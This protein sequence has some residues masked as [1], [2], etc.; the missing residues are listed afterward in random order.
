MR[1]SNGPAVLIQHNRNNIPAN[2]E[3]YSANE[4]FRYLGFGTIPFV[5]KAD[6]DKHLD[7]GNHI[8]VGGIDEIE[9]C[10]EKLGIQLPDLS[11]PEGLRI[12]L[13][14]PVKQTTLDS[15]IFDEDDNYPIFVKPVRGKRFTGTVL[16]YYGDYLQR[17]RSCRTKEPVWTSPVVDFAAEYR[18]FVRY[19]QILDV[20][21]YD[22]RW[23]LLCSSRTIERA[24]E[25]YSGSPD[26]PAAYAIDFG[27]VT[28]P[29]VDLTLLVEV[30]DG[31]SVGSYGL[32]D[33]S[34]AKFLS[35]RWCELCGIDDPCCSD[36]TNTRWFNRDVN[37]RNK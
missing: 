11:Y 27:V 9:H 36:G 6:L 1:N 10:A 29:I 35:A 4:G 34:Y 30:N 2:V 19:G 26:A 28:G 3:M 16:R 8:V 31:Y 17:H 25:D 5:T 20:R 14:R 15:V 24:V 7:H 18:V 22:G 23:D 13:G 33:R 12:Y 37:E 32:D 21:R